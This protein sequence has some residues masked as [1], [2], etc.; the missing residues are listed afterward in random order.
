MGK[1]TPEVQVE[2]VFK[3]IRQ[4][5]YKSR[6]RYK[7][8]CL[9]FANF[10]SERFKLQNIRNISDKHLASYVSFRQSE[11][12]SSKTI[13]NDLS[14]VRFLH[15][16]IDSPR[17]QLSSNEELF[18]Q[19]EVVIDQTSSL[20]NRAWTNKEYINFI[21]IAVQSGRQDVA[22]AAVLCRYMG[23]RISEAAA[24]KRAQAEHALRSGFYKVGSEAKNGKERV[25]PLSNEA[26]DM[27]LTRLPLIRRG[28]KLFVEENQNTHNIV[29]DFERFLSRV[30]NQIKTKEGMAKRSYKKGQVI[31]VNNL[32]WHGLRYSYIQDRVRQLQ[33]SG[34][35]GEEL[36][37]ILSKEIGH[38]RTIVIDVYAGKDF[39]YL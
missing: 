37:R 25:I 2:K 7:I 10:L 31:V 17:F 9:V 15:S 4:L 35:T 6:T 22:D 16:K 39:S 18:E 14:A 21:N 8:S 5:S 27:F 23:L 33:T 34:L 32:T 1:T 36:K 24:V 19:F 30:R 29:Q 13:K 38:E 26:K 3:H 12:I 20:G 11:G 28:D